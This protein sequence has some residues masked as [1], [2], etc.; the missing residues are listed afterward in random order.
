MS[1]INSTEDNFKRQVEPLSLMTFNLE[2]IEVPHD[3]LVRKCTWSKCSFTYYYS[4]VQKGNCRSVYEFEK[5]DRIGEGTYGVVYK[6]KDTR[7]EEIVAMKRMRVEKPQHLQGQSAIPVSG[8]REIG[9]LLSLSHPNIV[10]LKEVAIG[11]ELS[12]MYL[13]ME[14]CEHDLAR[15][16]DN[17][18][19]P[20]NE[21]QVKCIMLQ[22]FQA[23]KYLH[24]RSIVHRDLKVSNILLNKQG[25]L[26]LADFGLARKFST[27]SS[28]SMTPQVVTLWY[29]S[30][31]LLLQSKQQTSAIDIWAAGCIMGELLRHRPLFQGKNEINQLDLIID[32]LGTPHDGIWPEFSSLPPIKYINLRCQPHNH[33]T[34]VFPQLSKAGILLLNHLFMYDP[35]QRGTADNCINSLY[36]QEDPLPCDPS[37]LVSTLNTA[38]ENEKNA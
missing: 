2:L 36:F 7:N 35:K 4:L 6:A 24:S 26:K 21:S 12:R 10:N 5:I 16:L 27:P 34:K 38:E 32:L 23:L 11:N 20:F 33:L 37:V 14:F 30:P 29:R 25:I 8:I 18:P 13:V 22:I 28:G 19:E 9:L 15:V 17:I 31:E 3:K 1:E